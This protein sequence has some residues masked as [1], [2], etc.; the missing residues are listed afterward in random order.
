MARLARVKSETGMYHVM[1]RSLSEFDLFR[2]ADDKIKY[3]ALVQK[4]QYKYGFAVYAYCLMDNHGHFIIDCLGADI[5]KIM[6]VIDF[7]YAQYYN[8]KYKRRGPVFQDRFKSKVVNN[9]R[10]LVTLSA[11]I[12]NNPKDIKGYSDNV[13]SYPFSSLKEYIN[14]TNTFNILNPEVLKGI[15]GLYKVKNKA[16]YLNLVHEANCEE[17]TEDVEFVNTQTE[18]RSERTI[19]FREDKPEK[20]ISYVAE[21]LKQSKRSIHIKYNPNY[22]KFRALSCFLMS[23]FCDMTQKEICNVIG[24]ITQSRVSKL[25]NMGMEIA[26]KEKHL[27]EKYLTV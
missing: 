10:Y 20:I 9:E 24:N 18:Y 1:V 16:K 23:C 2:D 27:L 22:T 11:Y 14:E 17:Y 13:A 26:I 19:I 21:Y 25:S 4:Y 15:A 3:L 8:R 5:S 12:H 6:Q 7:C